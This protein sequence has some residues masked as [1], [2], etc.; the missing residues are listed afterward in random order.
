MN[1]HSNFVLAWAMLGLVSCDSQ[2]QEPVSMSVIGTSLKLADPAVG[3]VSAPS[4]LLLGA[5]AQGLICFDTSDRVQPALAERWIVTDDGLSYIFRLRETKWA[6]G[7]PVTSSDVA[8]S[9]KRNMAAAGQNPLRSLFFKVAA[10]IPMTGEVIEIRLRSPE[11]NLL[12]LLAAPEMSILKSGVGTGPFA[13]HSR[14]DGVLR[15][16]P[17][18]EIDDSENEALPRED[19]LDVRLRAERTAVAVARFRSEGM[20]Y[21]AG[22]TFADLPIVRAARIDS[23]RFKVDPV[24]GLFGLG[25][26]ASSER[27]ATVEARLALSMAI[28][29]DKLTG[30]FG[31]S[32]WSPALSVL[33]AQLDSATK[34]AAMLVLQRPIAERRTQARSII[35]GLRHGGGPL[36]VTIAL[37]EGEGARLLFAGLAGDWRRIGV[38]LR[39][40]KAGEQAD[41]V[42]IDEVAPVSSG[43][44]YLQKIICRPRL[45]CSED[46]RGKLLAAEETNDLTERGRRIAAAD[47]ATVASNSYIPIAMPM[48]WSLVSPSLVGW[49][50]S[51]FGA[52][53]LANLR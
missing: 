25:I 31:V 51:V 33:P 53:P 41:L 26:S 13:T 37:G 14:R 48:R 44:W 22:G 18:P 4:R 11:P 36:E 9:L 17:V 29:R 7:S 12:Q 27:L 45:V 39:M 40:A 6:D 52:H 46:A 5:M 43:L 16:R 2:P 24:Y 20:S 19:S 21:L 8:K 15:V 23:A 34:P 32:D 49:R 42:L 47:S 50:E 35:G 3:P 10:V 28:D 1:L 38:T 30:R